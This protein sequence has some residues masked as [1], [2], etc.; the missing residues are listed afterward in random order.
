GGPD[1][2]LC[3]T[4]PL[5]TVGAAGVWL[6]ARHERRSAV[7]LIEP[8]LLRRR[9]YLSGA[10][11]AFTFFAAAARIMLVLSLYAQDGLGYS[12]LGAGLVLTPAAAGNVAGALAAQRLQP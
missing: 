7:P 6:F 4:F 10:A 1:V 11:V 8:A 5:A 9:A 3:W 12:A 2:C